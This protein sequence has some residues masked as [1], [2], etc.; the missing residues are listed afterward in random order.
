[1]V[2]NGST[3]TITVYTTIKR[4]ELVVS[5]LEMEVMDEGETNDGIGKYDHGKSERSCKLTGSKN[6]GDVELNGGRGIPKVLT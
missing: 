1:M 5:Q 6:L 3:A 2:F 4:H